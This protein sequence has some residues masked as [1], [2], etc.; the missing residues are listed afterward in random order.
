MSDLSDLRVEIGTLTVELQTT[1]RELAELNGRLGVLCPQHEAKLAAL[2]NRL[3]A[4]I[5]GTAVALLAG[6]IALLKGR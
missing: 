1:R 6:I 3:W 5:A 4:Y 2:S